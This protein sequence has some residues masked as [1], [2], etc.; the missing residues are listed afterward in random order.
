MNYHPLFL[1]PI[2]LR[3]SSPHSNP[4]KD[5]PHHAPPQAMTPQPSPSA[6]LITAANL[7]QAARITMSVF[8]LSTFV[9]PSLINPLYTAQILT[10]LPENYPVIQ[11]LGLTN[12]STFLVFHAH[13]QDTRSCRVVNALIFAATAAV[14][15]I[16][17]VKPPNVNFPFTFTLGVIALA[18]VFSRP[19][20][21]TTYKSTAP[22]QPA[23]VRLVAGAAIIISA[24][25]VPLP[26]QRVYIFQIGLNLAAAA[27]LALR[28]DSNNRV[29]LACDIALLLATAGYLDRNATPIPAVMFTVT[30]FFHTTRFI[31]SLENL[32]NS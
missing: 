19:K 1:S 22:S 3:A 5:L 28:G 8:Q 2:P 25:L 32:S 10:T 31:D 12:L 15:L 20:T 17:P 21:Q 4:C 30:A 7:S 29:L 23:L 11:A 13:R 9:T 24:F 14:Y 6:K 26:L 16:I 27:G 18:N